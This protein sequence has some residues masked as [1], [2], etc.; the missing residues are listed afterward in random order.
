MTNDTC[1]HPTGEGDPCELP[2][3]RPDGKCHHHT[4]TEDT[5]TGRR[6]KIDEDDHDDILEAARDG[7]SKAGCAR[8]AGVEK[9]SLLRYLEAHEDFRTAFARARAK[10]ERRLATGPLYDR[11]HEPDMDGQHAR[12]LLSTSFDYVKTEKRELTGG[13]DDDSPV[14]V[15]IGGDDG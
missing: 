2:A 3:S 1:G 14:E 8:A 15:I 11:E 5:H 12:F 13:D 7:L 6:F 10:G 9:P 4:D